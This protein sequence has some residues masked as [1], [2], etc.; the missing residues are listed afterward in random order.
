LLALHHY[1]P[2]STPRPGLKWRTHNLKVLSNI[3]LFF[4]DLITAVLK[5]APE[6]A[7]LGVGENAVQ[8]LLRF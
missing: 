2:L 3:F 6:Q 1:R 7:L 8:S 4:S 5:E